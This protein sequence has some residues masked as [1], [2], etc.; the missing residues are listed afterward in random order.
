MKKR[1]IQYSVGVTLLISCLS[2]SASGGYGGG[3]SYSS[4]PVRVQTDPVY[5]LGK[6]VALGKTKQY[7]KNKVCIHPTPLLQDQ[8]PI[9][10]A[11]K[12]SKKHFREYKNGSVG[13]L[14]A[15]LYS[16]NEPQTNILKTV[17]QTDARALLY[18]LNSRYKL[19]LK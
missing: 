2:V 17:S 9:P 6:S 3:G 18:Y 12:L 10:L 14:A 7:G 11:I 5:E 19:K 4:A 15:N 8:N 13:I 1:I 16:C